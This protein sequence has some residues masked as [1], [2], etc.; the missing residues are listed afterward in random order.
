MDLQKNAKRFAWVLVLSNAAILGVLFV[1]VVVSL[2]LSHGVYTGMARQS[3]ENLV[4]TLGANIGSEIRLID[5]ALNASIQQLNRLEESD[6]LDAVVVARI[7][8][9]QTSL[10]PQID[11]I[12]ITDAQGWVLNVGSV[13]P[14][15]VAD[16]DYFLA[17]RA[18]PGRLII[19]E[20][21]QSRVNQLWG[22]AIARARIGS[23]GSFRGLVY[24]YLPSDYFVNLLDDYALGPAGAVTLRS[25]SLQMIARY[26]TNPQTSGAGIGSALV[27]SELKS[28]LAANPQK[29]YFEARTAADGVHRISA[30]Q[31]VPGYPLLLLVGMA[32]DEFL[33][34]WWRE[35]IR[36]VVLSILLSSMLMGLSLLLYRKQVQQIDIQRDITRLATE[37]E[38]LL[39]NGLVGMAKVK[40]RGVEWHNNALASLFGY[41]HRELVGTPTRLL[42]S[43]T[44]SFERI[45]QA[46]AQL[47]DQGQF[48]TQLQMR[49]KDGS[50]IWIDLSG[51]R[52]SADESLWMMVDISAVKEAE[53]QA[54]MMAMRDP[55]TGLANRA[56]LL[57]TMDRILRNAERKQLTVAV[58]FIDLDGFKS[59]NDRFG[60]DAGDVLLKAVAL[61][62]TACMRAN[63]FVARL[64]GD[65]FV[66]ILND[67]ENMPSIEI[68]LRRLLDT[69]SK[70]IKIGPDIDVTIGASIGVAIYPE[71]G[72]NCDGLLNLADQAMYTAKRAGKNRFAVVSSA[73]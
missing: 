57:E 52:L 29:G 73:S 62:M 72:L 17:A 14:V 20:P 50:L 18:A 55:L 10:I 25:E 39:E 37:R 59:V 7:A 56:Q 16:R 67:L 54:K 51:A 45:G 70:E 1:L 26:T 68:A 44:N 41:G 60:H 63:D 30:Y 27:S 35:A 12:R 19:S 36:A 71:H 23:D 33:M 48:R 49:K 61:R 64:G 24:S 46:Y 47:Q 53:A 9:E 11:P 22:I 66:V 65:E 42:Y 4:G 31:R 34:P 38:A 28:A 21:V 8:N 40:D 32:T 2:K 5:N 15:S 3:T 69:L 58:C 43:D 13:S 6:E